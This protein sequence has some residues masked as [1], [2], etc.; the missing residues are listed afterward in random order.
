MDAFTHHAQWISGPA[1]EY[2]PDDAGY[3]QDHRN[4]VL[5]RTLDLAKVP[6]S[7]QLRVAV[8]GF[9]RAYLNGKR[10]TTAELVGDWTNYT[11]LVYFN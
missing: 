11:K 4:H 9:A 10:V 5:L 8:L 3:Y 7:A 2:G 6:A 1:Y